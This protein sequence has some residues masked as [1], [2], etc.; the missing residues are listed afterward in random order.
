MC[1]LYVH[2]VRFFLTSPEP[3][4]LLSIVS[5]MNTD[6]EQQCD[7]TNAHPQEYTPC[8]VC[9]AMQENPNHGSPEHR[10][11]DSEDSEHAATGVAGSVPLG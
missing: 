7:N 5:G 1:L 9:D 6:M 10:W 11:R 2:P 8:P 4:S 3:L